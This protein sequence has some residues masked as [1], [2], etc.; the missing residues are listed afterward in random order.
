MLSNPVSY[1]AKKVNAQLIQSKV[2][3]EDLQGFTLWPL[4]PIF[5]LKHV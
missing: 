3:S 4:I 1:L 5:D 2:K